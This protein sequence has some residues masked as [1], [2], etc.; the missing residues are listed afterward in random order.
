M[1]TAWI[2]QRRDELRTIADTIHVSLGAPSDSNWWCP[3]CHSQIKNSEVS[4]EKHLLTCKLKDIVPNPKHIPEVPTH[5]FYYSHCPAVVS[6]LLPPH[7]MTRD[8]TAELQH[9]LAGQQSRAPLDRRVNLSDMVVEQ[10]PWQSHAGPV[11]VVPESSA[12]QVSE[13]A[14]STQGRGA[15]LMTHTAQSPEQHVHQR[16][17][18]ICAALWQERQSLATRSQFYEAVEWTARAEREHSGVASIDAQALEDW[19]QTGSQLQSEHAKRARQDN[20]RDHRS[21]P[22]KYRA[23][24]LI[25]KKRPAELQRDLV[26]LMF[27]QLRDTAAPQS[28]DSDAQSRDRE[29][30][31]RYKERDYNHDRDHHQ[32]RDHHTDRDHQGRDHHDNYRDRDREY[33]RR[34]DE[35]HRERRDDHSHERKRRRES[36]EEYEGSK[37]HRYR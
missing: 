28:R 30:D 10:E 21:R 33:D 34:G 29:R 22:E 31:E 16:V 17:N 4:I 27:S 18:Q 13:Y 1:S 35:R 20:E 19:L 8:Y 7:Q 36:S 14:V 32:G 2:Q 15:E 25:T 24:N 3:G 12:L 37:R 11:H 26:Q 9:L 23:K 5:Q 6:L